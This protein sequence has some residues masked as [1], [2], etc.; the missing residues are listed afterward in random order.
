[1]FFVRLGHPERALSE[2]NLPAS[3]PKIVQFLPSWR[4]NILA[5]SLVLSYCTRLPGTYVTRVRQSSARGSPP[6]LA[7]GLPRLQVPTTTIIP[8]PGDG[9][10][11][12][13]ATSET[14]CCRVVSM[15]TVPCV[16]AWVYVCIYRIWPC[17]GGERFWSDVFTEPRMN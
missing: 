12:A 15:H 1:M 5:G 11:R 17:Q 4:T 8:S 2:I 14:V 16:R 9:P 6:G 10:G 13:S 7:L 3:I